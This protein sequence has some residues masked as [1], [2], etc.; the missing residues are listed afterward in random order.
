MNTTRIRVQARLS[1]LVHVNH[2]GLRDDAKRH[3]RSVWGERTF[4]LLHSLPLGR[5][6]YRISGFKSIKIFSQSHTVEQNCNTGC[7]H[8]ESG[9]SVGAVP[10]G[11]LAA[12]G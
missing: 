9:R 6:S 10:G 11:W 1:L 4:R 5:L 2:F 3:K 8:P 12:R 7:S